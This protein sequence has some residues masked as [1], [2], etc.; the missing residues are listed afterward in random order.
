[1]KNLILFTTF[2]TV[3]LF[4]ACQ[5]YCAKCE[6][7]CGHCIYPAGDTSNVSCADEYNSYEDAKNACVN[8]SFGTWEVTETNEGVEQCFQSNSERINGGAVCA[9]EGGTW[10]HTKN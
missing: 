2:I 1:M 6:K 3:I 7:K 8:Q 10:I 5:N 4:S 9:S